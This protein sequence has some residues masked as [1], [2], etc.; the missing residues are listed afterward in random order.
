VNVLVLKTFSHKEV[1]GDRK[2]TPESV[3]F[4]VKTIVSTV[5]EAFPY[6]NVTVLVPDEEHEKFLQ[7][8]GLPSI[9]KLMR[10]RSAEFSQTGIGSETPVLVIDEQSLY[11]S[12]DLLLRARSKFAEQPLILTDPEKIL[13]S[14]NYHQSCQFLIVGGEL[15]RKK[16]SAIARGGYVGLLESLE[17]TGRTDDLPVVESDMP[18]V[19]SNSVI[20]NPLPY[21][22]YIEPTS[23]CNSK[24]IMCPFH[25]TDPDIA[26]GRL[27]LGD[28]GENMPLG[29]FKDLIDQIDDIGWNYLPYYRTPMI[30]AQLRGEPTLAPDVRKM[31]S[32]VKE[33][34]FKLSFSTNGATLHADG[35]I[36]YLVE[37]G[38]DEII[39]SIDGNEKEYARIRPQLNYK[40]VVENIVMLRKMRDLSGRGV[41]AL[42]TKRVHLRNSTE[43]AD[44]EYVER[45]APLVDWAGVAFENYDDFRAEAKSFSDYFFNVPDEK[46]LPCIWATDV[47]IVK[48]GGEVDLCFGASNHHIGNVYDKSLVDILRSS[49]LR[50]EVFLGHAAGDFKKNHF[51]E[52]CTSWK[53]NYSKHYE[54]GLYEIKMNPILTY[55]RLKSSSPK[56]QSLLQ[57]LKRKL[58]GLGR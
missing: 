5:F 56:P 49:E 4:R 25:S 21:H 35:L 8:S 29:L 36:E 40:Q 47:S 2:F 54:D 51:C 18:G 11:V 22:Y 28:G 37:I 34:G 20:C 9:C 44:R 24:C 19:Y 50:N 43:A 16:W 13:W 53:H 15:L 33:K 45:F 38:T 46:R 1:A 26:K 57:R 6:A 55:W 3:F 7:N 17:K 52:G 32:Y 30:T 10:I 41:P 42:Y 48:A 12:R 31:F 14:F 27:Y 23:R 39:V 58:V